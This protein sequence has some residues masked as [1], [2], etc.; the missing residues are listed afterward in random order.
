MGVRCDNCH[1]LWYKNSS[2]FKEVV[3]RCGGNFLTAIRLLNA[4]AF[5]EED[6]TMM[7]KFNHTPQQYVNEGSG[8]ELITMVKHWLEFYREA[9]VS[10][11]VSTHLHIDRSPISPFGNFLTRSF[12]CLVIENTRLLA[13]AWSC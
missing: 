13:G 9:K 8:R 11:V 1:T 10:Y 2:R 4:P 5:S 12:L 6:E 7:D 3:Q